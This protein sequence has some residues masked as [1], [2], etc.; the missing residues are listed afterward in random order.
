MSAGTSISLLWSVLGSE[1]KGR[2]EGPGK[3]GSALPSNAGHQ[4]AGPLSPTDSQLGDSQHYHRII[5]TAMNPLPIAP[6]CLVLGH[7]DLWF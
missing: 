5:V 2:P 1:W 7:P 6:F 3:G 4:A